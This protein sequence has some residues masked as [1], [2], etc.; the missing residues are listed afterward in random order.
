MAMNVG[1]HHPNPSS[2][3]NNSHPNLFVGYRP[4]VKNVIMRLADFRDEATRSRI[5]EA[6]TLLDN[7][8]ETKAHQVIQDLLSQGRVYFE[9]QRNDQASVAR[10]QTFV[11]NNT[12]PLT[13]AL[14]QAQSSVSNQ[15][16]ISAGAFGP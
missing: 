12:E 10:T 4:P 8:E 13:N 1:G 16:T 2:L 3:G 6:K 9:Q 15:N 5:L 14:Y 7:G 11:T